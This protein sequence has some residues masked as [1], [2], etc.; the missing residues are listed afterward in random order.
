[1][2]FRDS[3]F[4]CQLQIA[5]TRLFWF[6]LWHQFLTYLAQNLVNKCHGV[7]RAIWFNLVAN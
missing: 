5:R 4:V 7:W 6:Y 1:M 3:N 2:Q